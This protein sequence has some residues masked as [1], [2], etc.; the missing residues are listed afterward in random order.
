MSVQSSGQDGHERGEERETALSRLGRFVPHLFVERLHDVGNLGVK[1]GEGRGLGEGEVA[2][3]RV[4]GRR[5]KEDRMT[6]YKG[7]KEERRG[8]RGR[9]GGYRDENSL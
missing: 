9:G 3:R 4:G 1:E 6:E 2:G 8:E 7:R 5:E